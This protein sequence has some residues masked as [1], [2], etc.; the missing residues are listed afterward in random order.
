MTESASGKDGILA[1]LTAWH[2]TSAQ[3][4][5]CRATSPNREIS[6]AMAWPC[7]HNVPRKISEA[8]PAG[9]IHR[10]AAQVAWLHL[11]PCLIRLDVEPAELS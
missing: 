3:S 11:R 10:K 7:D 9:Y 2:F 4:T 1:D 6:A 5:L 8:S